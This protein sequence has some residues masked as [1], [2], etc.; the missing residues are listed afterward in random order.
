MAPARRILAAIGKNSFLGYVH[1]ERDVEAT[2]I[3]ITHS[4]QGSLGH[5]QSLS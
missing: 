5:E 2:E 1:T 3:M 4:C